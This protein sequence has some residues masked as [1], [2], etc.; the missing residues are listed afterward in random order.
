MA[1]LQ[2]IGTEDSEVEEE[3]EEKEEGRLWFGM[4]VR[5]E[6]EKE[7]DADGSGAPFCGRWPN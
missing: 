7:R 5:T 2:K 1:I 4:D 3:K 6:E